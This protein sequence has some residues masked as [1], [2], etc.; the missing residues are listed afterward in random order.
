MKDIRSLRYEIGVTLALFAAYS[1]DE[2]PGSEVFGF[3]LMIAARLLIV[4]V[5]H[6]ETLPGTRQFWLTRPYSRASLLCAKILFIL[7][8][9]N[10][11]KMIADL[12]IAPV[13][14]FPSAKLSQVCYGASCSS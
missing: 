12:I 5:V 1:L 13:P 10:L 8:F 7:A 6:E 14:V 2:V 4:R 9:I 11:P 3:L